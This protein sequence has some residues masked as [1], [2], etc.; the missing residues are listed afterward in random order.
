MRMTADRPT[1]P[2]PDDRIIDEP[3]EELR[4]FLDDIQDGIELVRSLARRM[5]HPDDRP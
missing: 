4:E 2:P 1:P 3:Y 5:H